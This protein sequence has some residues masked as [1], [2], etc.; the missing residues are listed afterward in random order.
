MSAG[1]Y[2]HCDAAGIDRAAAPV[3]TRNLNWVL[4]TTILTSGLAFLESSAF[5]VG[6]PAIGETFNASASDLQWAINSYLLPLGALLLLG[7]AAGDRF[8][9]VHLLVAGTAL[10]GAASIGCALAATLPWL[11]IGRTAQ[12][13]GAAML[14][15]NSLAILGSAFGGEA[16]GRAIGTWASMG[17]VI[18]AVGPVFGG[19]LIDVVGWRS[20]FFNQ[21][22]SGD[23]RD[24]IGSHVC[25]RP[26]PREKCAATGFA[27]RFVCDLHAW[28]RWGLTI[29]S[30]HE[31]WTPTAV[32]LVSGGIIL[33][34]GFLLIEKSKGK[35]NDANCPVRVIKFHRAHCADLSPLWSLGGPARARSLRTNSGC[36]LFGCRNR[37]RAAPVRV[38]CGVSLACHGQTSWKGRGSGCHFPSDHWWPLAASCLRL[39]SDRTRI[40]GRQFFPLL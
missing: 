26:A 23:R 34:L 9:R 3:E 38:S 18:A 37:R 5:N 11:L 36:R 1:V 24:R 33:M 13:V 14:M 39:E 35:R 21:P 27:W 12:G 29:G 8:G 25:P 22:S 2:V 31:G 20:I 40:T 10:F 16:R 32:L 19:W 4:I 30:G 7:G 28:R 17:A 6:L 15:P